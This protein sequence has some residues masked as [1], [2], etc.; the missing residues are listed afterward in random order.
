[1]YGEKL[2]HEFTTIM[3]V[4][5]GDEAFLKALNA[6]LKT[7]KYLKRALLDEVEYFSTNSWLRDNFLKNSQLE[8]HIIKNDYYRL[9]YFYYLPGLPDH[10]I[11][12]MLENCAIGCLSLFFARNGI[13]L[14][15][16][17]GPWCLDI[18]KLQQLTRE[19]SSIETNRRQTEPCRYQNPKQGSEQVS[20]NF[21]LALEF[22][23]HKKSKEASAIFH[24]IMFRL[25]YIPFDYVTQEKINECRE[26]SCLVELANQKLY[27]Y[28]A[29]FD[30]SP[31]FSIQ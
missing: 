11:E 4:P 5:G 24:L 13:D 2:C 14:N 17:Q 26:I 16:D 22:I 8:Q 19:L 3:K 12:A 27:D 7:S 6:Y 10:A 28:C 20:V 21:S 25:F 9:A 23:H 1:M 30:R 31:A 15:A 29:F 18:Q